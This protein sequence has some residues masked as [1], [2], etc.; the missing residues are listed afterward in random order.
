MHGIIYLNGA[1]IHSHDAQLSPFDAAV[2]YGAALFETLLAV[3][4]RLHAWERHI[5]RLHGSMETVG[6]E[7]PE[8]DAELHKQAVYVL[9]K[10]GMMRGEARVKILVSPGDVTTYAPVRRATVL[11]TAEPYQRPDPRFPWRLVMDGRVQAGRHLQH[12]S[13]SYLGMRMALHDARRMG[14]DD[15]ILLDRDGNIAESSLASVVLRKGGWWL[16]PDS[17]DALPGITSGL[18]RDLLLRRGE[19]VKTRAI[20]AEEAFGSTLLLCNSLLGPFPVASI[21]GRALHLLPEARISLLR[22]W[23]FDAGLPAE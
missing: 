21:N 15:L 7:I 10:N 4:G 17:D 3:D 22:S 23:W 11:I 13:T 19:R 16:F 6:I 20:A 9:R 1:L 12:K 5:A 14:F 2:Q 18:L 8:S